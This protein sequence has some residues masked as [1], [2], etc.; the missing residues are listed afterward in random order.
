MRNGKL[1]PLP[2]NFAFV[3]G[4]P[5]VASVLAGSAASHLDILPG[6]ELVSVGGKPT[7]ATSAEELEIS[8]AGPKSSEVKLGFERRR[9]DGSLVVLERTVKRERVDEATAIP[10]ALMLDSATGYVRV[11]TFVGAKV[12]DDLHSSAG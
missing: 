8:L 2:V 12:A 6:D 9:I 3:D 4:A 10:A 11:T 7:D 5:V 1:V